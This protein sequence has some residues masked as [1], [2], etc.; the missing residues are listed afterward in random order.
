MSVGFGVFVEGGTGVSVAGA[1]TLG[2]SK[3]DG[4][5]GVAAGEPWEQAAR[6]MKRSREKSGWGFIFSVPEGKSGEKKG[7]P[8]RSPLQE[9]GVIPQQLFR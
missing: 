3:G 5:V 1:G 6:Q 9:R 8:G 2:V 7:R 4:T